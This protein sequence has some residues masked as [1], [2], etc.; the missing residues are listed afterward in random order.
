MP[1]S[2]H[3][4]FEWQKDRKLCVFNSDW[5]ISSSKSFSRIC[6]KK[7]QTLKN[8][9]LYYVYSYCNACTLCKDGSRSTHI[10]E[11][12]CTSFLSV[13]LK[14]LWFPFSHLWISEQISFPMKKGKHLN[15]S[16][17]IHKT[18]S[19]ERSVSTP[20]LPPPHIF[21]SA[22]FCWSERWTPCRH[23]TSRWAGEVTLRGL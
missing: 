14:I 4:E 12:H 9:L 15:L 8:T 6:T 10:P 22:A 17:K 13:I 7:T 3:A 20:S 11:I 1:S 19:E 18:H 5:N 21:Y 16:M 2:K 23:F